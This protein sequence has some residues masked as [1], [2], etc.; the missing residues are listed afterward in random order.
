MLFHN[1]KLIDKTEKN[2]FNAW[3][4]EQL[5]GNLLDEAKMKVK[6]DFEFI[7]KNSNLYE[8]IDSKGSWESF[9]SVHSEF[10][11]N[12]KWIVQEFDKILEGKKIMELGCGVGNSLHWFSEINKEFYENEKDTIN[13]EAFSQKNGFNI[14]LSIKDGNILPFELS[15]CDFS[16]NAISM[17]NSKYEGTFFVHDLMS[18]DELPSGFDSI[19]LVF[20][21]SAIDPKFHKRVLKKAYSCL[22]PGGK[23]FFK[24]FGQLDMVQLR[25]KPTSILSENLYRRSDGTLTFF[26]SLEYFKSISDDFEILSLHMDKRLLINRKRKLDMYR[27][28][29]QGI[30]RKKY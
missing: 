18:E 30:L 13:M 15:G 20:T 7:G 2:S 9:Y 10:F 29:I 22:K 4:N 1:R 8:S 11:R 23:L 12:R 16:A 19:L 6:K 27:V 14:P 26:F 3:D 24:D 17:C 28:F 5:E 21:L 25:Y